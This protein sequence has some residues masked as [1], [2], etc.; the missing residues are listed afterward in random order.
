VLSDPAS[1]NRSIYSNLH[2]NRSQATAWLKRDARYEFEV[3][4]GERE[5]P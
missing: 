3:K 5:Q 4:R 2:V 1:T